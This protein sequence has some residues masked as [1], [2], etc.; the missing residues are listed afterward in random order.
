MK[1]YSSGPSPFARKV[2]VLLLETEQQADVEILDTKTTPMAHDPALVGV[3][4]VGKIPAL[5]RPDGPTLYDSRVIC[6]F[7]DARAG[8]RLYPEARLWDTLVLEATAEGIMEA[9]VAMTYEMRFRSGPQL[10]P[11]WLDAQWSRVDR[12]LDALTAR[13]MS[14]LYGPLDMGQIAV[15]C[16]LDYLDLRHADRGWRQ[17][18]D[19]LA[20]WH[21]GFAQRPAMIDTAPQA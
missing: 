14:H 17:N 9:A 4:P 8:G 18:R 13:W 20:A 15:G 1:L 12:S 7:L 5:E 21:K 16:A 10:M 6:R 2:R 3:N 19:A 11:D